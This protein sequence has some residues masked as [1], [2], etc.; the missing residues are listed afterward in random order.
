[1]LFQIAVQVIPGLVFGSSKPGRAIIPVLRGWSNVVQGKARQGKAR[2]GK[3][4]QGKARREE[5]RR[6]IIRVACNARLTPDSSLLTFFTGTRI[7]S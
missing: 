5:K 7:R 1:V 2:Q 6:Y 4:R 3:A